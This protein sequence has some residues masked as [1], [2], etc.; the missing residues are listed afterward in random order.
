MRDPRVDASGP[1]ELVRLFIATLADKRID[2]ACRMVTSD[3]VYDNVPIG[4]VTGPEGIASVLT[5]F[6][7]ACDRL[8]WVIDRQVASGDLAS[9][10]VLNERSDRFMIGGRWSTLPVAGVF[11]VTDG[12]I[13]LWRDFFDKETLFAAMSPPASPET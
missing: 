1:D 7:A 8:D 12:R 3:C 6:F 2:D 9:A 5:G 13:S 10:T 11:T 4:A